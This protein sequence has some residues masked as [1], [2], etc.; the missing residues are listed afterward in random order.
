[1]RMTKLAL[2]AS[3]G[4]AC[5][6]SAPATA[7]TLL[8]DFT[9]STLT[10]PVTAV[11]QLDSNPIPSRTNSQPIIN[12]TQ[13]FFDNISGVFNGTTQTASTIAFGTGLASQFQILGTTSG[14]AQFGGQNVFTGPVTNPVF[15]VGTYT[16]TGFSRGTL[17]IS[18]VTAA[19]PEPATWAMMLIGFGGIGFA[20]RRRSK[21]R[22][23]VS[24][25]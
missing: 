1:M 5:M 9:G 13:I 12:T 15:N 19:V 11:F 2:L 22:T 25:A 14:F 4:A 10:G 18:A 6:V 8:F 17:T 3:M 24:Y 21:V 16:F 7:A 23:T 20:M